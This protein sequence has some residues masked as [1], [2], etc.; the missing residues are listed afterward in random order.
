MKC[1]NRHNL[2]HKLA[3]PFYS[4]KKLRLTHVITKITILL[5][6]SIIK[7]ILKHQLIKKTYV[8]TCTLGELILLKQCVAVI[9]WEGVIKAPPQNGNL[10]LTVAGFSKNPT[11]NSYSSE[12]QFIIKLNKQSWHNFFNNRDKVY[13]GCYPS[14]KLS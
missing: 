10:C 13:W 14:S 12:D 7:A 2:P 4:G 5:G 1:Q 8:L 3:P 6:F 9:T 11:W